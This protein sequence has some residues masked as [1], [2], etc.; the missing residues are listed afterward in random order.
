MSRLSEVVAKILI[1]HRITEELKMLLTDHC[2]N[3]TSLGQQWQ[4]KLG[5]F[6]RISVVGTITFEER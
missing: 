4:S 1:G 5:H 2:D 6:V 3:R